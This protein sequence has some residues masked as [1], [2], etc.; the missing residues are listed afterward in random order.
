L[1]ISERSL[2]T[3]ICASASSLVGPF[4]VVIRHVFK[5]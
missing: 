5:Q 2:V 3:L 4:F 1:E